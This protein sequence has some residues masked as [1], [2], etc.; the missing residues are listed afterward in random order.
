MKIFNYLNKIKVKIIYFQNFSQSF[1]IMNNKYKIIYL[2][3]ISYK[4]GVMVQKK[5]ISN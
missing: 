4:N 1:K 2:D 5:K 3:K